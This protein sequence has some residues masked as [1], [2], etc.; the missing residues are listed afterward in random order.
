MA[1][2]EG[3]QVV[4]R[5]DDGSRVVLAQRTDF[6]VVDYGYIASEPARD[7]SIFDLLQGALRVVTGALA[8]RSRDTFVLRAP[9]ATIGIRGT[10]FMVAVVNPAYV[11]VL[12][13]SVGVS[14]AGGTFAAAGAVLGIGRVFDAFLFVAV[15]FLCSAIPAWF[16]N[17]R[18]EG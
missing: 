14:N 5:F 3:A 17:R 2:S 16:L 6:R 9:Q 11:Q 7:R 13:G 1:T 12:S 10:D 15:V 4:L 18:R 8:K